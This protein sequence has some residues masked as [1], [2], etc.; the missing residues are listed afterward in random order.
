M[1]QVLLV[2]TALEA[3]LRRVLSVVQALDQDI[4]LIFSRL[5]EVHQTT[6]SDRQHLGVQIFAPDHPCGVRKAWGICHNMQF[7]NVEMP[8][9]E[10]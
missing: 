8:L 1:K 5:S 4:L 10:L 6:P 2:L 9:Q 7:S 3:E